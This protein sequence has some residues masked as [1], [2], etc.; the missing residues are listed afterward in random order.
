MAALVS[1]L[2]DVGLRGL[3]PTYAGSDFF[4]PNVP[5]VR[6]GHGLAGCRRAYSRPHQP[7]AGPLHS[8]STSRSP[9]STRLIICCGKART[10]SVR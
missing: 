7:M 10:R 5:D 3:S 1:E 6:P 9:L 4:T 2:E 8:P